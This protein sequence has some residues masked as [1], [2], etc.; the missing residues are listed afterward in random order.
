[1][2]PPLPP[3]A[4]RLIDAIAEQIVADY[5]REIAQQNQQDAAARPNPVPLP[6]QRH[7]A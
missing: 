5:L 2:T 3:P 7:A 1:M 4:L 6:Q